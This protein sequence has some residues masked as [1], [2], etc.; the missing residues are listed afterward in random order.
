MTTKEI[1]LGQ[2]TACYDENN[3]F[4]ALK[5]ALADL[6]A[7]E[8]DWRADNLDNSIRETVNHLSFWNERWLIK[9]RNE[10]VEDTP[11]NDLTFADAADWEA[12]KGELFRVLDEWRAAL[13]EMD[14]SKLSETVS[15]EYGAAW[16]SPIANMNIH[17]AYHAGQ[18]ILLRKLQGVWDASKGVS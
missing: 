9:L 14:E 7:D 15:A 1:L 17:N 12:A 10:R 2:F 6:T 8:A 4:V 16:S 18:I 3:W 5:N 11:E 13:R